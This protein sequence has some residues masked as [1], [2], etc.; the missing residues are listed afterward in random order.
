MLAA[1]TSV[2]PGG[3]FISPGQTKTAYQ[4]P[5]DSDEWTFTGQMGDLSEI[6]MVSNEFDTYLRLYDPS[7]VLIAFNDDSN[8]TNSFISERLC[9]PGLY[10][11]EAD[12]FLSTASGV[13]TLSLN[14]G[15]N[16][17]AACAPPT[18][19]DRRPSR[20]WNRSGSKSTP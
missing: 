1:A 8:L 10:T 9:V 20:N 18:T 16:S 4:A 7:G 2:P 12:S 19:P 17:P 15:G 11:I 13:Y 6:R 3:G 14:N 5:Y